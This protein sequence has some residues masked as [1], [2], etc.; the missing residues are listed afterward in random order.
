MHK[1]YSSYL[2]SIKLKTCTN[3]KKTDHW[4]GKNHTQESKDKISLANKDQEYNKSRLG[5][6]ESKE[7]KFKRSQKL[8][9]R[10]PGFIDKQH[11]ASTKLKMR[12]KR[13][14]DLEEK[15]GFDWSSPNY[16]KK[17]CKLF[18]K[19]NEEL[20]WDGQHAERRGEFK[21]LGYFLDFY[22]KTKNIVI[23][24]D[25]KRHEYPKQKQ[26]DLHKQKEV[27]EKLNCKFFRIKD[28]EEENWREIIST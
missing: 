14:A 15:C 13:L 5:V 18:E 2:K 7:A 26:K 17:A 10:K 24:F 16:N 12:L 11:N 22:E 19:I 20:N 9:G 23:E 4:L 21:I 8:K 28:G 6:I 25:E 27:I 3:C 1:S